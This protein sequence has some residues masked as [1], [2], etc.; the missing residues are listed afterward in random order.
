MLA[1]AGPI[2][3]TDGWAFEFKWDGVRAVTTVDDRTA[4]AVSRNDRDITASYPELHALVDSL[5]GRSAVLDGE[6]VA[7]EDG[8]PSFGRLQNRMHVQEPGRDLLR[9]VP[10]AYYVFDV[11]QLDGVSLLSAPYTDRRGVLE[12]LDLTNDRELHVPPTF[13]DVG[14]QD[15]MAAAA[16]HD[17]EGVVA[18]RLDS[19]YEPGRR[20]RS[21]LK[22]ARVSTQEVVIGGWKEGEGRRSGT[23]GALLLGAYDD[24]GLHYIGHVGTGFTEAA[25]HDLHRRLAPLQQGAS[26]FLDEVPRDRARDA[27]WVRPELVGEVEYRQ[28]TSEGRLRHSSWRGLRADKGPDEA[29]LADR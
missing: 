25:L 12:A 10:V 16:E 21:W 18:K 23:V 20:S 9:R 6:I 29:R 28:L 17:L 3:E 24:D 8:R 22:A 1:T 27:H 7:L 15:V 26:P 11:L 2:P 4:R 13:V 5:V 14:G 19:R